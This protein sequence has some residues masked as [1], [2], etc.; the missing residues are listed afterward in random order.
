M[1]VSCQWSRWRRKGVST[2]T[3]VLD[4]SLAPSTARDIKTVGIEVKVLAD[5]MQH[6][7]TI[8]IW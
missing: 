5:G 7:T 8:S 3:V 4:V 6:Q 1:Y 2:A